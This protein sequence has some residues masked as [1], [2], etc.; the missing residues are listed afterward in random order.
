LRGAPGKEGINRV[1]WDL[2]YD[3]P[4]LV[5]LRT[6]APDNPHIWEE[7]R[8]RGK[9]SRPITHWGIE[10]SQS[11]PLAAPGKYTV[12]L[13]VDGKSYTQP[14]TI[15]RDPKAPGT[16][17]D[18]DK[19]VAMLLRIRGDITSTSDMVNQ[20]EWMR[21]QLDDVAKSLHDQKEKADLLKSVEEMQKKLQDVEFKLISKVEANSDDK[22]Y[23]AAYKVY[24]NLIWLNAEVGTGGGDVAGGADFA[25]T[26]TDGEILDMIEK[27]LTAAKAD[28]KNLMDKD[29]PAFNKSLAEHGVIPLAAA[30][31]VQ[32]GDTTVNE[33]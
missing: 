1:D 14:V 24:L 3:S 23:V 10:G 17:A 28:Y 18:I 19:S 26:A 30:I 4:T 12:R 9:D 8:F 5:A 22:Y 32:T 15:L 31:P 2:R 13:T 20:I 21:K 27:D 16:D 29:V 11:G 25:P 7:A 33:N 6:D